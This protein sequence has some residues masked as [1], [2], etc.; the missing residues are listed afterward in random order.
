ME[1]LV[2]GRGGAAARPPGR[3][4]S[5]GYTSSCG[6]GRQ[7]GPAKR[8]ALAAVHCHAAHTARRVYSQHDG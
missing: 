5:W 8:P 3:Q 7:G 4:A 6:L 1:V 2:A